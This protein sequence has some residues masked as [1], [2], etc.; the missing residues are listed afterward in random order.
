MRQISI[1]EAAAVGG[2][3]CEDLTMS[4]GLT[5]V[6]ISGS[7]SNWADCG[8]VVSTWLSDTFNSFDAH[9]STGIPYGDAHVG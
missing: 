2:G 8:N 5:G 9:L 6:S 3:A 1:E 7:L 4:I